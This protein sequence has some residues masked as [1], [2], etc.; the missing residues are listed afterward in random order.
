MESEKMKFVPPYSGK[1]MIGENEMLGSDY[2]T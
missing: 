2:T 1:D